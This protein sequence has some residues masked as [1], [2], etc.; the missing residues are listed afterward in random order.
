MLITKNAIY[1]TTFLR[2]IGR[3]MQNNMQIHC[4]IKHTFSRQLRIFIAVRAKQIF[5]YLWI[6]SALMEIS[7]LSNVWSLGLKMFIPRSNC[8]DL[9][10]EGSFQCLCFLCDVLLKRHHE[11]IKIYLVREPLPAQFPL[12][13][14]LCC[15]GFGTPDLKWT[16]TSRAGVN[17]MANKHANIQT[18]FKMVNLNYQI[19]F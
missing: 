10:L 2:K 9:G 1:S 17:M 6:V 13:D 3:F 11:V 16:I 15:G 5:G 19:Y 12:P 4:K 7:T 18:I 8:C 14:Q